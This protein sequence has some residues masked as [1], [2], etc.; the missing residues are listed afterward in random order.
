LK[1]CILTEENGMGAQV[2]YYDHP[3]TEFPD[4]NKETIRVYFNKEDRQPFLR[5]H[6][7]QI[8]EVPESVRIEKVG[9][10]KYPETRWFHS[11]RN[12]WNKNK[13]RL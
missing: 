8:I 1:R 4:F 9:R 2:F 6:I 11:I 3:E 10:N 5:C 7:S 12:R 13:S